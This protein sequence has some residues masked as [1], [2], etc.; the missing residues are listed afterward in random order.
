MQR[1][2]EYEGRMDIML[3]ALHEGSVPTDLV[4]ALESMTAKIQD[5]RDRYASQFQ[6]D[7]E[8]HRQPSMG[9][10]ELVEEFHDAPKQYFGA[11]VPVRSAV[12]VKVF[13]AYVN[14]AT[15][16]IVKG[17][18]LAEVVMSAKQFGDLVAAPNR[19]SGHPV[20]LVSVPSEGV[21][22]PYDPSKDPT[23]ESLQRLN[24]KRH[25]ADGNA[26]ERLANIRRLM[27]D[28]R[29][30]GKVNKKEAATLQGAVRTLSGQMAGNT[31]YRVNRLSEEFQ[32]RTNEVSLNVHLD[33]NAMASN[34]TKR[35]TKTEENGDV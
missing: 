1:K 20:T 26:A 23:K 12:R 34:Q 3:D 5:E 11:D 29:E 27:D 28:V 32:N 14:R 2:N 7:N 33:L 4:Q 21:I 31:A 35:I 13:Q 25:R 18:L 17:D 22:A 15:N 30:K 16:D 8:I 19:G 24:D 10:I 9:V 6:L